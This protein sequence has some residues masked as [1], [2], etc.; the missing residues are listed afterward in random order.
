MN[1]KVIILTALTLPLISA[2]SYTSGAGACYNIQ[3]ADARAYCIAKA[4]GDR[5]PCY[6]IQKPDLRSLCLAEV[7]K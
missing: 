2:T 6:N 1:L 4:R 5:S 7:S 3:D